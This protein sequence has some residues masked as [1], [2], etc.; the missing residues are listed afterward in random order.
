MATEA[1]ATEVQGTASVYICHSRSDTDFVR[2]L[3][4]ALQEFG[5]RTRL[6]SEDVDSSVKQDTSDFL[7]IDEANAFLFVMSPEAVAAEFSTAELDYAF[8]RNK[9]IIPVL[10][11]TVDSE[12]VPRSL[13]SLQWVFFRD[14]DD[15]YDAFQSLV[16]AIDPD[17]AKDVDPVSI[18]T[19]F[20]IAGPARSS[21]VPTHPDRPAEVD[22]LGHMAFAEALAVRV[23]GRRQK[24]KSSFM[25]HIYGP[26]GSGKS[27]L[28]DFLGKELKRDLE[29]QP[30]WLVISFNAWQ[31]QRIGLPWWWLLDSVF[32]QGVRQLLKIHQCYSANSSQLSRW[33]IFGLAFRNW[34]QALWL[35]VHEFAWRFLKAGRAPYVVALALV[36]GLIW[37][38]G[39]FGLFGS[40]TNQGGNSTW[41]AT[42]MSVIWRNLEEISG[43]LTVLTVGWALILGV[44]RSLLPASSQAA[45][46]F[47]QSTRDP[48]RALKRHFCHLV[49]R[50]KYPV[51]IF[52]DDLDRCQ[53]DYVVDL[54]EGIQTLFS[55]PPV[56]Y[57]VAADRRWVY[58][59]YEGRYEKFVGQVNEPGRS[60][61][62]L[63]L[64]KTFQFAT[65]VPVMSPE[66]KAKYWRYLI[67]A[68]QSEDQHTLE[69]RLKAARH[70]ARQMLRS[71]NTQ[72]E[73]QEV[74][75]QSDADDPV[76][77]QAYREEA[78]IRFGTAEVEANTEHVLQDFAGL[79]ESNPRAMKRLVNAYGV[80][81]TIDWLV[82]S[83]TDW[84]QL[85]LYTI[86][87]LRWPL[88]AEYLVENPEMV[89]HMGTDSSH[90]A[91][92]ENL[93]EL[94]QNQDVLDVIEGKDVGA[95]L[96]ENAI[97]ALAGMLPATSRMKSSVQ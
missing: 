53:G 48:M 5:I 22:Q 30:P 94:F 78:A 79:L 68:R 57:V 96:D 20:R 21:S 4:E 52:I 70:E 40:D 54:L 35:N 81:R 91:A 86:L 50:L 95:S 83:N 66:I 2:K 45:E 46:T 59:S 97:R 77:Q 27:T 85:I 7:G 67:G 82:R 64:Q 33:A 10:R 47:L 13:A 55:E 71:R 80:N 25:V 90:D 34:L 15:P 14:E 16:R 60:L 74:L 29:D 19:T 3:S 31:H 44:S 61:G 18:R 24:E 87:E 62:Y 23:R 39:S 65:P 17:V 6:N 76:T 72:E 36:F 92:P 12:S 49:K 93:R 89:K 73:I 88:L 26:W 75:S 63:F 43:I 58:S 9:N 69:E 28:L 41:I 51:A 56:V 1:M 37:L 38:A 8:E 84:K 32:R 11:R 42:V